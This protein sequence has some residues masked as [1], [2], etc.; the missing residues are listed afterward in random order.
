MVTGAALGSPRV[1]GMLG[2]RGH[3]SMALFRALWHPDGKKSLVFPS[4]HSKGSHRAGSGAREPGGRAGSR[5][6]DSTAGGGWSRAMALGF[7]VF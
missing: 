2:P 3:L 7:Q 1:R 5:G 4:G 6:G